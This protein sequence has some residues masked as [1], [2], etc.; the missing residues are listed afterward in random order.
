VNCFTEQLQKEFLDAY[1]KFQEDESVSCGVIISGKPDCFIAGA[2]VNILRACKTEEQARNMSKE[3]QTAFQHLESS[4]KPVVA[5]IMGSCLGGGLE[6]ALACHYR[7]AMDTKQTQLGVPEVKLGLIPGAGGTQR[8]LATCCGIDQVLQLALT[9][10]MVPA[11]QAK[12]MGLVHQVIKPLGPGVASPTENN[13]A[14][15]ESIAVS[16]AENLANGS[17]KAS[18]APRTVIQRILWKALKY[19]PLRK[20][21]FKQARNK[22]M[23]QSHG[24]YPAPM[25][26][27][28][29]F[30]NSVKMGPK[31]GYDLESKV[32]GELAMTNECKALIGLFL[33]HTE[34]KKQ[35]VPAPKQPV[36]R[37][38][39]LGAGL[40]GAGIAQVSIQ[41]GIPTVMKDVST[42]NLARGEEYIQ[43]NFSKLVKRKKMTLMDSEKT[44]TLL[45]STC[46]MNSLK[47]V[48]LVIEA[49]FEDLNVK[50]RVLKETEAILPPHAVFASNTSALPIHQIAAVSKR[51]DKVVGMHYF[52]P[53]ERM[54]LLELIVTDKTSQET[55]ASAMDV[56]LRQGKVIIVVKD[57]P[58]FYTTRLLGPM[59]SECVLILQEG[60]SPTDVDQ[61]TTSFGWPVGLATLADEVGIDVAFHVAETL[62]AAFP[63]RMAGGNLQILKDMSTNGMRGRKSGKGIYS[64]TDKKGK[65]RLENSD[66]VTL[67]ERYRVPAKIENTRETIQYRLFSRFVNEAVLCLQDGILINGPV[68]GDIGAVFGLGFPPNFGG[69]FRYLDIHGAAGLVKRMEDYRKLYGDH[70]AP[71]ELLMQHAKDPS[72]KFH[73]A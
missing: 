1:K 25:K 58:G 64:Y 16:C 18:K 5:A 72:K 63:T 52:S 3:G 42:P 31:A 7:I 10:S 57:A 56:G 55:L 67:L 35:R 4:K 53:V 11:S 46:D 37:L 40:M 6:M 30:E 62:L 47:N 45:N 51:P 71:C 43:A 70:F 60:V 50:H 68:E 15:L 33:G 34:C 12:R 20:L 54:E 28:D 61:A 39:V 23:K 41:R 29:V 65:H 73:A 26:L 59:L 32:F 38:G 69:P 48:D 49:V 19:E 2:D 21:F 44:F 8:L 17:L 66:A 36:K 27:V 24:L 9:G 22:V 13:M 14:Y